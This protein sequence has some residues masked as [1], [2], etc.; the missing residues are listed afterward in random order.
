VISS[1][2]EELREL[3]NAASYS[4]YIAKQPS[5]KGTETVEID[6]RELYSYS[7]GKTTYYYDASAKAFYYLDESGE[8]VT[9]NADELAVSFGDY[10]GVDALLSPT[11]GTLTWQVVV[12]ASG[13]YGIEIE[14]YPLGQTASSVERMLYL[15]GKVPFSQARYLTM[16][17]TWKYEYPTSENG[18]VD[19]NGAYL[20][21]NG[22]P[23]FR[24]DINGNQLKPSAVV[25]PEWKTYQFADPNGFYQGAFEFY[26]DNENNKNGNVH[27]LALASTREAMAIKTIRLFPVEDMVKYEDVL[28][29]YK[30]AGYQAV[31]KDASIRLEAEA[32]YRVS[33]TSVYAANDRTSAANSPTSSGAQLQNVLGSNSYD[34]VGQWANYRFTVTETGLYTISVR[35]KQDKL[36][37]MYTSRAIRLAGGIYGETLDVPFAEAYNARFNYDKS[38]QIV[39]LGDDTNVFQF[40]FEEGKTYTLSLEVS[41]GTLS[42]IIERVEASLGVINDCYLDILKLTGAEPD[43]YRDYRFGRVMPGTVRNLL[44]E[45]KRLYT[46]SEELTALCGS[47]GAH[48]ATLD[49]VAYLLNVMGSEEDKIAENLDDLKSYIGTLGTWL[50]TSKQQS[51]M[52]DYIVISGSN[53]A[54]YDKSFNVE[55]DGKYRVDA[56]FFQAIGFEISSFFNS[57]FVDYNQMGVTVTDEENADRTRVEVWLATGRDQASIWRSLVDSSF[58]STEVGE[59]IAV[60][61]KLV[62]GGTLL[63]SVLAK[64]GPDV[65]V[66]L[67][68]GSVINYAIRSAVLPLNDHPGGEAHQAD[69]QETLKDF[70]EA[71]LVP[72]SMYNKIYGVPEAVSFSMMFYRKD[73]L[74]NLGLDVPKTWDDLLTCVPVFQSANME[75]GLGRDYNLFHYQRGGDR[76]NYDGTNYIGSKYTDLLTDKTFATYFDY[77]SIAYD[78][79]VAL[80]AFRYMTR[81]FTDYSFPVAFDAANRFRTGEMPIVIADAVGMYNQLTV[82]ATEIRGLWMFTNVPGT[83]RSDGTISSVS[84]AGVSAVVMMNGVEDAAA[85][86]RFMKWQISSDVQASYGNSMVALIGP[87]AKYNTANRDALFKMSWTTEEYENLYAQY[88]NLATI[89]NYPGAYIIDRYLN[90]AFL[91]SYNDGA[92]PV[93][94]LKGYVKTINKEITRKR[95]EFELPV[96]ADKATSTEE[97]KIALVDAAIEEYIVYLSKLSAEELAT[98]GFS[99]ATVSYINSYK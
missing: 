94:Q 27:T 98:F 64:Q 60:D 16:S 68:S 6:A 9:A 31:G 38:W 81:F 48:V 29:G 46:V 28:A 78:E 23:I 53:N 10:D 45:S 57:F 35:C 44:R 99:D 65:Y 95:E 63:P 47:K 72:L 61:L 30:E 14:Y 87:S 55:L 20:D 8:K 58:S 22:H 91:N 67:D 49:K 15:N 17:K 54:T 3:L 5:V 80:D 86:W 50:N 85:S 77:M 1:T 96:L 37:G 24:Q 43:E 39:T 13:R 84:I 56:T 59:G 69:L 71:T 62:A 51:L 41:L 40:Y 52:M 34:T 2:I 76:W 21:E 92:D 70:N 82:F 18:T 88:N 11:S 97:Q 66:G 79:D 90:F 19:L 12:P 93:E 25:A 26:F 7:D 4:D 32:P 74:A 33:D 42:T 36:A 83:E 75:I 89:P 73:A